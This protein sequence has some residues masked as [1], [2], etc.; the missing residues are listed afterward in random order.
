MLKQ[1]SVKNN[2]YYYEF[3]VYD[4]TRSPDYFIGDTMITITNGQE[5]NRIYRTYHYMSVKRKNLI[6]NKKLSKLDLF[7]TDMSIHYFINDTFLQ[8]KGIKIKIKNTDIINFIEQNRHQSLSNV[9]KILVEKDV[10]KVLK[11]N[12]IYCRK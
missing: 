4:C 12:N 1:H 2:N 10:K 6:I 7:N 5:D 9:F 3:T 8:L 11:E